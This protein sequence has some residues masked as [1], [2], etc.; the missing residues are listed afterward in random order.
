MNEQ[1]KNWLLEEKE[2]SIWYRTL[3][4]LLDYPTDSKEVILAKDAVSKCKNVERLFSRRNEKGLFPHKP[5]YGGNWVTFNY[6]S[7]LAE[8]GVTKDD[9]RIFPIVDWILTP[10]DDKQEYFMQKEFEPY[11]YVL[12][13]DNMGG[14]NKGGFLAALVRLGYLEDPRVKRL[15]DVYMNKIRFDGGYLCK[16]KKSRIP[17]NVPKSC[18]AAVVPALRLYAEL[19]EDYKNTYKKNYENLIEYFTS[20]NMIYSKVEPNKILADTRLHFISQILILAYSMSKLGLGNIPEMN[21]VWD[22]IDSKPTESGKYILEFQPTRKDILMDK[23]GQPNKWITFFVLLS[24][25]YKDSNV[26]K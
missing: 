2:P 8:L 4:E 14:C 18:Y 26:A 25:R 7:V 24:K 19:P 11:A 20:R 9:E 5:E 16:W 15:I 6:L 17:G 10:G 12:D 13:D 23:V 1:I 21:G 3:T 22:I